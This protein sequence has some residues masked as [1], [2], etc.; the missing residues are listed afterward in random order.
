[1]DE[2]MEKMNKWIG[3]LSNKGMDEWTDMDGG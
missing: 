2:W 1:M 3:G